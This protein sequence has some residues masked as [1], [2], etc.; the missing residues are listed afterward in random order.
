MLP[1]LPEEFSRLCME[2]EENEGAIMEWKRGEYAGE[3]DRLRN[4]RDV[5]RFMGNRRPSEVALVYLMKHVQSISA[6]VI[7]QEYTWEWDTPEG[8]ALKQRVAD[9]RNYLLLLAACLQE[10]SKREAEIGDAILE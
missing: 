2:F 1:M 3:E 10:E 4:F 6:A 8:E 5:A 9:A 7:S